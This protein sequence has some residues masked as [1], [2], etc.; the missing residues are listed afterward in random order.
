[1]LCAAHCGNYV[2][3]RFRPLEGFGIVYIVRFDES[4]QFGLQFRDTG[5]YTAIQRTTFQLSEPSFNG[6]QP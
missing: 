4:S 2:A 1:M 6:I 5:E 3:C